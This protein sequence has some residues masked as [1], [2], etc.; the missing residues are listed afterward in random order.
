VTARELALRQAIMDAF[1]TNAEP[2]DVDDDATLRSLAE[3]HVVVLDERPGGARIRMAH[4]FAGHHR[5]ARV[6][7]RAGTWWG[8]CA[9]DGLGIVAALGLREATV[10]SNGIVVRVQDGDVLDDAV[11]HV[12][13]PARE[14]WADIGFT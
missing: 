8:N 12:A 9:W 14:W 7:A 3:Q 6:D 13:V 11:F 5:G 10:A 4:P 1:A 2:P